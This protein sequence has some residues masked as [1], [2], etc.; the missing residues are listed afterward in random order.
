MDAWYT[1]SMPPIVNSATKP[2]ANRRGVLRLMLPFH[3][4]ASQLKIFT[5]VGIATIIVMIMNGARTVTEMPVV[6]M[7]CA[8]TRNP[9]NPM[10]NI[11]IAIALYPKIGL[12]DIFGMTSLITPIA[13]STMMYTAGWE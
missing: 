12:R 10:L 1:P 11:A 2:T 9:T 4:V 7:W 3:I 13:G 5:P 6:N 8:Q